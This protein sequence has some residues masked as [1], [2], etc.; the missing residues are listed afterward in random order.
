MSRKWFLLLLPVLISIPAAGQSVFVKGSGPAAAAAKVNLGKYTGYKLSDN[1]D[2]T[3]L[4]V[5]QETWSETFLDQ[6]TTAISMKLFSARGRL[7]WSKTEPVGSRSESTVVQNL[8]KD[9]AK[10]KLKTG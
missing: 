1:A 6:P 2:H 10:S 7:L 3:T 8:L 5:R 4:V 9:L